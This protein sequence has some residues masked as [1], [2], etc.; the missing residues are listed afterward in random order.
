MNKLAIWS[1]LSRLFHSFSLKQRIWFTF[2]IFITVG[3]VATGSI[4]YL[5]ASKEIQRNAMQSSQDTVNQSAQIVN[6]RLKNIGTAVR[7]LMFS[8]AFKQL[9]KDVQN[10]DNSSY[11]K[12]LTALQY[13][14][15]Q[16]KFNDSMIDS[17]LIATPIGDFYPTSSA[18]NISNSFFESDM[19][20]QFQLLK[21]GFWSTGHVDPFFTGKQRVLSLVAEGV[22]EDSY[23]QN[24]STNV[25]VVINVKE[26]DLRDLFMD[27]LSDPNKHYYFVDSQG[28]DINYSERIQDN[29]F[30]QRPDFVK[31]LTN[32]SK[33][34]FFFEDKDRNN[35][36]VN[37]ARLDIK[38]DWMIV[39]VQAKDKLLA[40]LNG[41]KQ[42]TM[43]VTIGF[44]LVSL[45]ITNNLTL[46]LLK[47]LYRL[48][49]LMKRVEEND[50]EVRFESAYKDE[51]S[52]VGFRFN[53][54]LDE[55][56][57]LIAD[58]TNRERDKRKAEIKALT[59]QM[60]PHFFYNTLNTIYC[61]SVL[62]ENEDVNE[63][64]LALSNMFQLSLSGGRDLIPLADELDHVR[65]YLA[66]QQRSYE[67]LF[68]CRMEVEPELNACLVP[69]II[70]QPLIENSILHG[71]K[72][73]KSGGE[74]QLTARTDGE[75]LH[76]TVEDNGLGLIPE[77]L[78]QSMMHPTTSKHG[79]ALR[80]IYTRLELYYGTE[81][82]ME[83][84]T[85]EWG[86]ARIELWLPRYETE[87]DFHG[88]TN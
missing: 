85:N 43:L 41:I 28:A 10:K 60:D 5:I 30:I 32:D 19:F 51:V 13:V 11:Y 56:K 1:W 64:I 50:L 81:Q 36:L 54:M 52:Q 27:N 68:V 33:G 39:G 29:V 88:P 42:A 6:E 66:I 74:I 7:A 8:D 62:G 69:K 2:V 84:T 65:Q 17:I 53:R 61:K 87:E 55:I 86:G 73:M 9:M 82:R 15:N 4:A 31:Q 80:N 76:I 35:Y 83:I 25:Y 59:A 23:L 3:L 18:R 20:H 12:S 21:R 72:D 48:Q 58:V 57:Q 37:Y 46:L 34:S 67:N 75:W 44:V 16:V 78:L 22:S 79:Y 14:F 38:E 26:D 40:K 45:L 71:F 24:E 63:M 47:P 77:K 70:I 49:K